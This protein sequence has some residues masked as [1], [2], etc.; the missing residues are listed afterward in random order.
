[1]PTNKLN[2]SNVLMSDG[3][4][5]DLENEKKRQA[6]HEKNELNE[7]S[8]LSIEVEDAL[9]DSQG[10]KYTK[11]NLI[12]GISRFTV[13]GGFFGVGAGGPWYNCVQQ[14]GKWYEANI[15]T[16]QGTTSKP[17]KGKCWYDCPLV[18]G[19]VAD[20]CSG[21]VQACL[22]LFGVK[23]PSI[24]TS[25]M[26]DSSFMKLMEG[27][28]F[29]HLSGNWN[30][31]NAQPGDILCGKS[32]THTEIYAGG[33]RSWSWGNIHDNQNGHSGMPCGF[34][35]MD[36]RGGYIHCWRKA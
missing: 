20:D 11:D 30:T 28:G 16:Y 3:L 19:K 26:Q 27:A 24:S 1:M 36:S 8:K 10:R 12:T 23:C 17:R 4:R 35:K 13:F 22:L 15:H 7:N 32:S 25:T 18:N 9:T 14:M 29:I 33:G 5:K 34:C 6:E 31:T 2:S 21:F